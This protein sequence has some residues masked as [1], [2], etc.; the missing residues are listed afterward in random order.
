MENKI[1]TLESAQYE[2]QIS[3]SEV[4]RNIYL[5]INPGPTNK[6]HNRHREIIIYIIAKLQY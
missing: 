2:T 1:E 4:Y 3:L 5:H 6:Y